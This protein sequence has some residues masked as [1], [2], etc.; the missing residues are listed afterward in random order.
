MKG[1]R[2]EVVRRPSGPRRRPAGGAQPRPRGIA[3][4]EKEKVPRAAPAIEDVLASIAAEVPQEEWDRLP[5]DLT[6]NPDHYLYGA[7][8]Q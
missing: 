4:G 3:H 1:Q 5:G 6:D 8:K 2:K 7:P